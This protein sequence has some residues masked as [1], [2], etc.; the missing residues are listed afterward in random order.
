[1]QYDFRLDDQNT[2]RRVSNKRYPW[3]LL[4][5][6]DTIPHHTQTS[7][8]KSTAR[9][10]ASQSAQNQH[11]KERGNIENSNNATNKEKQ[12]QTTERETSARS[13]GNDCGTP[14]EFG[15]SIYKK[16][17]PGCN[18][19]IKMRLLDTFCTII[20]RT[21]TTTTT[22]TTNDCAH[23]LGDWIHAYGHLGDTL[24]GIFDACIELLCKVQNNDA[25][26][27]NTCTLQ[28]ICYSSCKNVAATVTK[29]F[30]QSFLQISWIFQVPQPQL[31][32]D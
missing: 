16:I 1:M 27:L 20:W 15:L 32:R 28:W 12:N 2:T 14:K 24:P 30:L 22:R 19:R 23:G 5:H 18:I 6:L 3:G 10:I 17:H 13:Q 11:E 29:V 31:L 7:S 26:S 8:Y 21:T 25:A 9:S 4:L